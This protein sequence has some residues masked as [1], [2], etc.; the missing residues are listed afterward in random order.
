MLEF[1]RTF[2]EHSV[3]VPTATRQTQKLALLIFGSITN[4]RKK[5]GLDVSKQ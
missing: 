2:T 4:E 5:R 1:C 3:I